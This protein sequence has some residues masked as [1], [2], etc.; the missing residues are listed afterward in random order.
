MKV[1]PRNSLLIPI[2]ILTLNCLTAIGAAQDR[3]SDSETVEH[4]LRFAQGI[5]V[6]PSR[7]E[8]SIAKVSAPVTAITLDE[9][10]RS[11]ARD[12]PELLRS[13]AGVHVTDITGI[14]ETIAL[15]CGVLGKQHRQTPSF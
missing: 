9:I 6:T 14:D 13:H 1:R 11:T 12:I 5:V 10:K 7:R 4:S 8:E 2:I 15:T 3:D